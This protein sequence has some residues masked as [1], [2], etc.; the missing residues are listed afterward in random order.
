MSNCRVENDDD[1]KWQP[2]IWWMF[3]EESTNVV[4]MFVDISTIF[5]RCRR[6][7]VWFS[8][9][10]CNE[11]QPVGSRLTVDECYWIFL[12]FPIVT[13]TIVDDLCPKTWELFFKNSTIL[14]SKLVAKWI[15]ELVETEVKFAA[16]VVDIKGQTKF[17]KL[18]D[19]SYAFGTV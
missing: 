6:S 2:C 11:M 5:S 14:S 9:F 8:S 3:E 10:F 12:S 19:T 13:V 18:S 15:L 1:K 7:C 17:R 4:K 16:V